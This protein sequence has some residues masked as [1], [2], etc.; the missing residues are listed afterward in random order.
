MRGEAIQFVKEQRIRCLLQGAWFPVISAMSGPTSGNL[1]PSNPPSPIITA[2]RFVK[3]SHDR[4]YLHYASHLH[5]LDRDPLVQE[6]SQR[7]D[8]NRVS[9]VDS[10]VSRTVLPVDPV[11]SVPS[12]PA[13]TGTI[14]RLTIYGSSVSS[15]SASEDERILLELHIDSSSLASE[16]LDGLL[17][18]L[19]QQPITAD[20]N[21][22]IDILED[23]TMKVRM[24]NL[25]WEDV[26]WQRA[27]TGDP[28]SLPPRP[29]D[30]DYW[31]EMGG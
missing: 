24:S 10:S 17:M 26:D 28:K 6:L 9:S 8:L 21:K 12:S 31:Y 5:K 19:N 4:M 2:W 16:W 1:T 18:L 7:I 22:L 27:Q 23:W 11:A 15:A 30:S 13:P 3:L 29:T 25:R 20:T 14:T